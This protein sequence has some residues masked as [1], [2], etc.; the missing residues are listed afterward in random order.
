[1]NHEQKNHE[2]VFH[3]SE[4]CYSLAR[5]IGATLKTLS[6]R[7]FLMQ[8]L[9]GFNSQEKVFYIVFRPESVNEV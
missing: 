9:T 5:I 2:P 1:M 6:R 3:P 8:G 7:E 4:N